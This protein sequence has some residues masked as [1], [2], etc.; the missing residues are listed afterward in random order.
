MLTASLGIERCLVRM[1]LEEILPRFLNCLLEFRSARKQILA[2]KSLPDDLRNAMKSDSSHHLEAHAL[3]ILMLLEAALLRLAGQEHPGN[4]PLEKWKHDCSEFKVMDQ[5]MI[6]WFTYLGQ[7]PSKSPTDLSRTLTQGDSY[8]SLRILASIFI[9]RRKD[10]DPRDLLYACILLVSRISQNWM[11]EVVE[12]DLEK[13]VVDAW[14]HVIGNQRFNLLMPDLTTEA[15]SEACQE[16][17]YG[18][19][20][21]ARICLAARSA[22]NLHWGDTARRIQII[23]D[24]GC[25]AGKTTF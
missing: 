22:V 2:E 14:T 5:R 23:A 10:S 24:E 9:V 1:E 12:R 19:R 6:E 8:S 17:T 13:I 3:E 25:S 16:S 15:I 4:P 21:A 7:A 18:V 11:C 20:K